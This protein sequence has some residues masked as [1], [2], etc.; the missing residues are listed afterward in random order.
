MRRRAV[1]Q[2]IGIGFLAGIVTGG[3][4][5]FI[6]WLPDQASE[7]AKAIDAAYWFVVIICA[8][9]FALVAGVSLYSCWKFRA[10]PDDEDDGSPIHGHTGLEIYWT[11]VPTILVTAMAVFSGFAL[12]AAE[13]LPDKH[14]TIQV[15][16]QQFAWSFTYPELD[17][18]E[19]EL[20]LELDKPMQ[21]VLTAKDVIHSFWVPEFRMKQ[22]AVPGVET[23]VPI[24]PIKLGTYDVICTEL[25]GLGHSVMRARARVLSA[26][27]YAKWAAGDSGDSAETTTG[28]GGDTSTEGR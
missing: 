23:T 2:M 24:T 20:V 3:V 12:A 16:A 13:D 26:E 14:G 11:A 9:I 4:A 10:P 21:L 17:R 27:D 5:F 25:C 15:T 18:T 1:I 8:V 7:E 28:E 6:P 19:G 22:D